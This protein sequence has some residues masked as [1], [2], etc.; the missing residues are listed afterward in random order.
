MHDFFMTFLND[1]KLLMEHYVD[2]LRK[3]IREFISSKDWK[4]MDELIN[5]ALEREQETKKHERSP[6]KR[7]IEH[8]GSSSKNFKSNEIYPRF[9][10]KGYPQCANYEKFH[11]G[12]CRPPPP[13]RQQEPRRKMNGHGAPPAPKPHGA[14]SFASVQ[15]LQR[16]LGHVYE[17][18]MAEYAKEAHDVATDTFFVNLLPTRVLFDSGVDRSHTSK[19]FSQSFIVPISQLKPSLDVEIANSKIIHVAN[20]FQNCEIE[21]DNEK[22]LIDLIYMPMREFD[23]VIGTDWLSKYDAII[24]CQNKLIRIRTPSRGETFIYGERKKTSLAICT[25][26]RAKRHLVRGCQAY[27]AHIIDT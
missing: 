27:L 22:L 24:S 12:E 7:R 3:E 4:N 9:G 18:M 16:P 13:P 21:I 14:P 26:A 19:L 17:M 11:P 15:R 20:V 6:P 23:V 25:Y 10:R 8:G 2:M 1:Q 5:A